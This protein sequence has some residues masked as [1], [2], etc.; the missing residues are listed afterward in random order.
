MGVLTLQDQDSRW[1]RAVGG[2]ARPQMTIKGAQDA[3]F[4]G[5]INMATATAIGG[6]ALETALVRARAG[7]LGG[8]VDLAAR[9]DVDIAE[10]TEVIHSN[11]LLGQDPRHGAA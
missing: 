3:R 4:T 6:P 11:N 2:A 5:S 8:A 10:T 1:R 7:A 9:L